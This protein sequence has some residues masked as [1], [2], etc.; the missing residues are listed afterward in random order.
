MSCKTSLILAG[1]T[2]HLS[3][4]LHNILA[5]YP[6]PYVIAADSGLRHA[7][8]LGLIPDM[9]VGDFDSVTQEDLA[10][11]ATVP[12]QEHPPEKDYIDLELAVS[13]AQERGTEHLLLLGTT[14]TRLDQSLTA[15]LLALRLR[16][17]GVQLS[18]HSGQ[19]DIYP[20]RAG[21]VHHVQGKKGTVFSLLNMDMRQPA[22]VTVRGA[23]YSITHTKLAFGVGHGISNEVV[24][25]AKVQLEQGLALLIIEHYPEHYPEAN[26]S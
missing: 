4:H 9:L 10:A 19:Q 21:D 26:N 11:F 5:L 1:G 25:R 14:G 13:I 22:I 7:K 12:R 6:Q 23:K 8:A 16:Q 2:L 18:L 17:E 15:L 3:P 20:L 24:D